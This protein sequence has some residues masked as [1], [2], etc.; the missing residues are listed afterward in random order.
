MLFQLWMLKT[1]AGTE[2]KFDKRQFSQTELYLLIKYIKLNSLV[3]WS[4]NSQVVHVKLQVWLFN[5]WGMSSN[6]IHD[7]S[8][9]FLPLVTKRSSQEYF[10]FPYKKRVFQGSY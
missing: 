10:S 6:F 2:M 3:S 5:F 7:Y 8:L 9:S 1:E 4:V